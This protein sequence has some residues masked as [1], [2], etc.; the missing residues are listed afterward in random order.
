MRE[1]VNDMRLLLNMNYRVLDDYLMQQTAA[2]VS[3]DQY[4]QEVKFQV[5]N[6]KE[7]SDMAIREYEAFHRLLK[8]DNPQLKT[9]FTLL[10]PR[11]TQSTKP[12]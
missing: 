12:P 8:I 11:K 4:L 2:N 9:L 5:I 7:T 6:L 3:H 1:S 10:S